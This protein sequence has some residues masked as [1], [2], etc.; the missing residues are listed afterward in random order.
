MAKKKITVTEPRPEINKVVR[1]AVSNNFNC[2]KKEWEQLNSFNY[3]HPESIFFVNCNVNTPQ[4]ETINNHDYK[5]VIT[6]NPDLY[7]IERSIQNLYKLN[8]DKVSFVRVKY[9]PTMSE[10]KILITRLAN[11]GYAVVVTAQR[12]NGKRNLLKYTNIE[13]YN[14]NH[15][16]YRLNKKA[17]QELCSFV[18]DLSDKKVFICDRTGGGCSACH[19]CSFLPTGANLKITSVNLSSSGICKFN[20]PDCYA[21]T[22]QNMA[23][24]LKH[25]PL[26]FDKIKA[27]TKQAGNSK[28][29]KH[30]IKELMNA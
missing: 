1:V 2:T 10:H 28:H 5:S 19:L 3:K 13:H 7:V 6:V 8:Q 22:M 30:S 15:N 24:K 23:V 4:L 25:A 9:I 14:W 11:E 12:W 27:N 26:I 21:K 17:M 29:I 18:D 16:R 20:C